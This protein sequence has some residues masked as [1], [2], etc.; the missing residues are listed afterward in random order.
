MSAAQSLFEAV[1][2]RLNVV[3]T[4]S[5]GRQIAWC[6]FH[7]DGKG[8][9]PHEPNFYV[10]VKGFICH[11][12]GKTGSIRKL[13]E[14][15]GV[16]VAVP[17]DSVETIYDYLDEHGEIVSQVVRKKGKKF[18]QRQPDGQ[19]GWI[20][21]LKGAKKVPY[22][23][24]DLLDR[25]EDPVYVVE[26]EQ[27]ADT[28]ADLGLLATTNAGGAGKWTKEHSKFLKG[29]TAV[30]LADN[31]E[32]GRAHRDKVAKSLAGVGASIKLPE[33]PGLPEKGDVTDWLGAGHTGEELEAIVEAT[34][35]H[36]N[37]QDEDA[38]APDDS[39]GSER[40]STAKQIVQHAL[41]GG[42]D[43]FHDERDEPYVRMRTDRG[44]RILPIRSRHVT[45]ALGRIA[46]TELG[47]APGKETIASATNILEATAC[48]DRPRYELSVRHAAHE[49]ALWIDLDG[50]RA[51][52]VTP[53]EWE[54][55]DEP[56]ILF[57]SFSHQQPLPEPVHGGDANLVFDF[58]N[59]PDEGSRTLFV[60]HL[61]ASLIP[62]IPIACLTV[63][64][65]QGSAKSTLFRVYKRLIDPSKP[66]V[67]GGVKDMTEFA[68]ILFQNR[69]VVFDNFTKL[70]DWQSD[71]LCGAITG[72]G[73]SKR[74]LYTDEDTVQFDYQR[75]LAIG[76]I[77]L[78]VNRPDLL[79]RSVIIEM[80]A[81]PADRK[82]EEKE[83]WASF[84]EAR[85]RILGGLLDLLCRAMAL[86][87][88]L[89]LTGRPRMADYYQ[90]GAAALAASGSS[91]ETFTSA[92]TRNVD[93]QCDAALEAS[94]VGE[95]M[96]ALMRERDVWEGT[97]SDLRKE[98]ENAAERLHIDTHDRFWPRTAHVLSRKVKEIEPN[99]TA[100]G[101]RVVRL[102]TAHA[103][104]VR[105]EKVPEKSVISVTS[106]TGP[107]PGVETAVFDDATHGDTSSGSVRG[108][109]IQ[110]AGPLGPGA[111]HD[112]DDAD[113][114]L[115]GDGLTDLDLH[116][117][118]EERAGII[119]FDA[120]KR[121]EEAEAA[122]RRSWPKNRRSGG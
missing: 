93:A 94:H 103:R 21:N 47:L 78:V 106:V 51:V 108:S 5:D 119:E 17:D 101:I 117:S 48:L 95:P 111:F 39:S 65:V 70:P 26:G 15:V 36:E 116:E 83:L 64:G 61:V 69:V 91:P 27:D 112:G 107:S 60:G 86:Q 11:A 87:A 59:L 18:L 75:V 82:R 12:C 88:D 67:R 37:S 35:I 9:P 62:D 90:W 46:W 14:K 79:D 80:L 56:P 23:L 32:A 10:S 102:R 105:L 66:E 43:L 24:P 74:A 110:D 3:K 109:V 22:R 120:G 104:T 99:L 28:L 98:L 89:E 49:G 8:K 85:P 52:R 13:A 29:R 20:W 113:D 118:F 92:Y 42:F 71:A 50:S 84:A 45:R 96:L 6:P 55:V 58:V 16:E 34:P 72:D 53:G 41:E 54:L 7:D 122:A 25:P 73:W 2:A 40:D 4:A 33:L 76:G 38:A 77:N 100:R 68:Q 44:F 121:R 114:A 31:D 63:H 57:R 19:G 1:Q 97:F 30:I 115:C 81:I